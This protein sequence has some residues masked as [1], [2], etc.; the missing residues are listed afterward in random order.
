M[1]SGNATL[2]GAYNKTLASSNWADGNVMADI[3]PAVR[4]GLEYSWFN[5]TYAD[6]VSA[7]DH[8]L[9]ASIFYIF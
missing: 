1:S 3:T 2:F 9:Q 6:S 8:R 7:T 4:L 5:Q